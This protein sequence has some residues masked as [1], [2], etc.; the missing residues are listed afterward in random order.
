[1]L[2]QA[3]DAGGRA[4]VPRTA[5]GDALFPD[6][7]VGAIL[8]VMTAELPVTTEAPC[9][10]FR[11]GDLGGV[12]LAQAHMLAPLARFTVNGTLWGRIAVDGKRLRMPAIVVVV[13]SAEQAS[14]YLGGKRLRQTIFGLTDVA[15]VASQL[16][17]HRLTSS[18]AVLRRDTGEIANREPHQ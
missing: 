9:W 14:L 7:S 16:G 2:G 12:E 15:K 8:L 5:R 3:A 1:V 11:R 6:A 17:H 4:L 18:Y 13:E 10:I